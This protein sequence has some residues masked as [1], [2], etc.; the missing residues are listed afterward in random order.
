MSGV[1]KMLMVFAAAYA[2]SL[3]LVFL[4]QPRLVYFPMQGRYSTTP[5]ARGLAF[6]RL[7]LPTDDGEQLA[8]WWIPAL[9][10]V[11][12][13][14][15]VLLFHGNAGTIE[16]RI[17]YAAMFAAMGYHTLLVDYRGYGESSGSPSEQGTYRDAAASWRWLTQSRGVKPADIVLFGESLGGGVATW[18]AA[19]EQPRALILASTFTSVPALGAQV[20]PWLPVRW[21]ARIHYD[22][23][24]NLERISAPLLIAHSPADDIIPYAHGQRLYAAAQQPKAMLDLAGGH[25]DGFVFMREAWRHAL[26]EF[27]A[28]YAQK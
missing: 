1:W 10:S 14:G 6:E 16:H 11:P 17:D 26:R 21:L 3:V 9:A 24:A 18:L 22:N 4:L 23:L 12:A 25:N 27:L 15:T 19:R 5:Q 20:Y 2:A 7:T 8:A 28:P 13:H